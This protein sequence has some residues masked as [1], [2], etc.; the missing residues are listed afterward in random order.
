[1]QHQDLSSN[2]AL[3]IHALLCRG[4]LKGRNWYDFAWYVAQGVWPNLPHLTVALQRTGSWSGQGALGIDADWLK[5]KLGSAI[6][7]IDW[8]AAEA[9]VQRFLRIDE[10]RSLELWSERFF[11]AKLDKLLDH[12]DAKVVGR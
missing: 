10:A 4:F 7:A 9:D 2:F 3:K 11:I 1:M 12:R 6:T 8:R 5:V